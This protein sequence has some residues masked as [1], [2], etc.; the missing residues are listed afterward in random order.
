V[1]RQL[2]GRAD[3]ADGSQWV[4][5]T[6]NVGPGSLGANEIRD[7][8][9]VG[10]PPSP[11][12]LLEEATK[13][14]RVPLPTPQLSPPV[15]VAHLVGMPEWL[16][17]DPSGF[18]PAEATAAV[19]ALAVTLRATPRRTVWDMGNGD[20]VT[21]EGPGTAW[22]AGAG[23]TAEP[24]CGYVYQRSST[25]TQADGVYHAAVTTIWARAWGCT[26]TCPG[27]ALPDLARTTTFDLTVHQGQAVI[28]RP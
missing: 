6:C 17:I 9:P 18:A 23:R 1:A 28:T 12:V 10:Q 22:S 14:L 19:P 7:L 26:P 2:S 4:V 15:D 27:G 5:T 25:A 24:D 20:L 16:A 3:I 8:Q 13:R 11:Y 21:C